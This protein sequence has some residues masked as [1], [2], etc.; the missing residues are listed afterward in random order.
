[1]KKIRIGVINW[2]ASLTGDTYFGYYQTRSLSQKKYRTWVPFYA[3]LIDEERISYHWRSAGEYGR[4]LRYAIDAGIDYFA[5]VWY[6]H[7]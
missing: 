2:D 6:C 7:F 5:Y 4:E 1:M 3:D